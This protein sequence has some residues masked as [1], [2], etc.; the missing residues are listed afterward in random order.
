MDE[1]LKYSPVEVQAFMAVKL[2]QIAT[3]LVTLKD[4]VCKCTIC[5]DVVNTGDFTGSG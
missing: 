4:K 2:A 3:D 5:V 1:F